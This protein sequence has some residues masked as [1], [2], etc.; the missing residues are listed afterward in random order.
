MQVAGESVDV[1]YARLR[2]LASTCTGIDHA[3]EIRAQI[4]HACNSLTLCKLILCQPGITLDEILILARSHEL[5][6]ARAEDMA[7]ALS[8]CLISPP[9]AKNIK[10]KTEHVDAIHW[11]TTKARGERFTRK[12]VSSCRNCG[13]THQ[14]PDS[15]PAQGKN[16]S[17]CGG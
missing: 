9:D 14:T 10:I 5:A 15:C 4:I 11:F 16:C 7:G 3:S 2:R 6:D 8:K 17:R 12:P 13:Q 1:Y